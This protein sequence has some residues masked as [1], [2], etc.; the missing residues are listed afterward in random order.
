MD[1]AGAALGVRLDGPDARPLQS[2]WPRC[3]V[4]SCAGRMCL[5]SS[6]TSESVAFPTRAVVRRA[7]KA[8]EPCGDLTNG[9]TCQRG[10]PRNRGRGIEGTDGDTGTVNALSAAMGRGTD[11]TG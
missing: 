9:W 5:H 11:V 2:F 6:H 8:S 4:L 3:P 7:V 1:P 10:D